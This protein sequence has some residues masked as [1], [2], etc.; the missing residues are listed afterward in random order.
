M[1]IETT[2]DRARCFAVDPREFERNHGCHPSAVEGDRE[3]LYEVRW[4][5]RP[6]DWVRERYR[7]PYAGL[8]LTVMKDRPEIAVDG[9]LVVLD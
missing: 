9:T 3:W 1:T 4:Q 5:G 6:R 7:G 8:L 2:T